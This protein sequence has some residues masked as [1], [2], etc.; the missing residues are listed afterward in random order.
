MKR[1]L[2]PIAFFYILTFPAFGAEITGR[3]V[4]ITDGDTL[5]ILTPA[6]EQIKIRLAEID[7]PEH[8]QPYGSRAKQALSDLAY[9]KTVN[10]EDEGPDRYGR[11]IGLIHDGQEN[12]NAELGVRTRKCTLCPSRANE[13]GT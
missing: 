8:D 13:W 4:A 5:K 6:H 10:I 3:V 11:T 1:L 9:G 7:A 2:L 12:V